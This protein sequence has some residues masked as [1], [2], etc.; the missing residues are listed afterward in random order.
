MNARP[1]ILRSNLL[2]KISLLSAI[3]L[4]SHYFLYFFQYYINT[5]TLSFYLLT[6]TT[7]T[8]VYVAI[9]RK[10]LKFSHKVF[11]LAIVFLLVSILELLNSSLSGINFFILA[12]MAI[13]GFLI[14]KKNTIIL[15]G[16]FF[17]IFSIIA[18]GFIRG[19]LIPDQDLNRLN[20]N[21]Y[22]WITI[23]IS[24]F[25]LAAL[26]I[27]A[28]S[29]FYSQL[30]NVF[31]Q[32][33]LSNIKYRSLFEN[34]KVA[35][36]LLDNGVF[37]DCNDAACKLYA[38][39]KE[40][41]IG[42]SPFELSP[43]YQSTGIDSVSAAK[44]KIYA[45]LKGEPQK[46]EWQ[47][48]KITGEIF[49]CYVALHRVKLKDNI[50]LQAYISDITEEK[51]IAKELESYKTHL[52][53][54]VKQRTLE[55]EDK[56]RIVAVQNKELHKTV[57]QLKETQSQLLQSEKMASLGVLTAGV[58]HEINNPLQYLSGIHSG[59]QKY[60]KQHGSNEKETTDILLS[61]TDTAINRI[62]K[63]VKGLNQ[64][65]RDNESLDEDCDIHAILNNSLSMLH[66]Q[67]INR[68]EVIMD[69]CE[70]T[71]IIPGNVGKL[72]Q[73]FNN[74]ISNAIHAIDDL[75]TITI[76]TALSIE[77]IIVKIMDTG[78]GISEENLSKITDP[79]FSTKNPGIGTGLGLSISYS[80]IKNHN[81]SI[82]FKSKLKKGT[83]VTI[84][85]PLINT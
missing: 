22:H 9:Q 45:A 40:D 5:P 73:V 1:V 54:L 7:L 33:G 10:K 74:V 26:L 71:P 63:I 20:Q 85:I 37:F 12:C 51:K 57:E 48:Q 55:L 46:F 66:H 84:K 58:S 35:I 8:A 17:L 68:V 56:N 53:H 52:E 64:F 65:S 30:S 59:F 77:H 15:I 13:L 75:G 82:D 67:Y 16:I 4:V 69:Y 83:T 32:E 44:I 18:F 43:T 72:H 29:D 38:Q 11:V 70:G 34:S 25:L 80:I 47:H 50:Y 41:L 21:P 42:M 78:M 28:F 76:S 27:S 81:G 49:D 24:I 6:G 60:F 3:F 62:C 61:S 23:I 39:K 31:E 79:F 14:P 19:Y 36:V 2:N